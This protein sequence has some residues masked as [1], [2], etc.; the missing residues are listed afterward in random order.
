MKGK[1]KIK[2]IKY[3][4]IT[5]QVLLGSIAAQASTENQI[6]I[7][8]SSDN[9]YFNQTIETLINRIDQSVKIRVIDEGNSSS[10]ETSLLEKSKLAIALG[11]K[12]T[13]A[14]T[15]RFPDKPTISAYL[16]QQQWQA[17]KPSG[18]YQTAVLLDQPLERYLAFS[19]VLLNANSV[20][21]VNFE[22]L[23]FNQKQNNILS[24]LKLKLSQYQVVHVDQLLP[25]IRQLIQ[26]DDAMLMLPNQAIYNRDTLKGI[27]LTS[28]RNRIPV[29]SYSP[30]HVKSGALASIYSSPEDIGK[31]L[32]DLLNQYLDDKLKFTGTA[33]FARYYSIITNDRVAHSLG[34]KLPDASEIRQKLTE[35]IE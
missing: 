28:Y 32:G 13:Q 20:G 6:V 16:T 14:I 2:W 29:I 15:R 10:A 24:R 7:V 5:L 11:L 27:L 26:R 22:P 4:C 17:V 1:R 31:H 19:H 35:T 23:K 21:I 30:A 12:A 33:Q 34:F 25:R 3:L 8:K 9:S 18:E